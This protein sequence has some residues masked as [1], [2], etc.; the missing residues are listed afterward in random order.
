VARAFV[1]ALRRYAA[2][3]AL[4]AVGCGGGVPLLHGAHALSPG[5]TLTA[6]GFSGTFT[7]GGARSAVE[8]ARASDVSTPEREE[9][10]AKSDA[11]GR[12]LAP[13]V[14]PFV[15][16]RVGIAGDNDVGIS[17]TGRF[18]RLDARH[19]FESDR[20]AFSLGAGAR[21]S[22]NASNAAAEGGSTSTT[23]RPHGYGF[24]VPLLVGWRSAAGI[25]SLWGGARGGFDRVYAAVSSNVGTSDVD[26]TH[27]RAGGV[28]GL[29]IGFRRVH[30][31]IELEA[32][33]HGIHG[34][35]GST[36]VELGGVSLTP[37]GGLLFTF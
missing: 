12:A 24:D 22:I 31:A 17:Y 34:S 5:S 13:G 20:W 27:W 19:V 23:P 33:Y 1:S 28:A 21:G 2:P 25:V 30:A 6:A 10:L 32:C 15:S 14:A 16:M 3:L 11:V 4:F 7:A 35:W 8:A 18:L 26:L 37:A 36:E 29:A 9:L